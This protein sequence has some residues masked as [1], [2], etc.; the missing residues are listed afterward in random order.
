MININD[1]ESPSPNDEDS[2]LAS[3]SRSS[4]AP[5][6][7]STSSVA[8]CADT[9][10]NNEESYR[11]KFGKLIKIGTWNCGGL[12]FTTRELCKELNFDILVLTETHDKGSLKNNRNFITAEPAPEDD[13]FSGIAILFSDRIAKCVSHTGSCGSRI[14]YAEIK[15][16][17]C[18]L[19]I[20]GVYM[21]H[22]MRKIYTL[23]NEHT[24]T[25]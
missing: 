19:F 23:C 4:V 2:T 8:G 22:N 24:E 11:L 20:I 10:N 16:K 18:N 3:S 13:S 14:V 25:T 1:E 12:S 21:P 5:G 7:R 15:A 9:S 17:P 6:M